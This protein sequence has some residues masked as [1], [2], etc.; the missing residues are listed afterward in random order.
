MDHNDTLR[1]QSTSHFIHNSAVWI[2]SAPFISR[3]KSNRPEF[4]AI[5]SWKLPFQWYLQ[6]FGIPT[7]Y[8]P[9]YMQH[10]GAQTSH[11]ARHL[12]LGLL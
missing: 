10:L 12:Q 1:F 7:S 3:I 9:A 11:F 5:W 4:A 2:F 6:H 8:F